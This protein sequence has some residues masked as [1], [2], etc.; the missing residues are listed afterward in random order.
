MVRVRPGKVA[1][2][3]LTAGCIIL[4]FIKSESTHYQDFL[5]SIP[6]IL[7]T[8][9]TEE[10][11][12]DNGYAVYGNAFSNATNNQVLENFQQRVQQMVKNVT[13][14]SNLKTTSKRQKI[15]IDKNKTIP[16]QDVFA[17]YTPAGYHEVKKIK[18]KKENIFDL[19]RELKRQKWKSQADDYKYMPKYLKA[20]A[21][22]YTVSIQHI[23]FF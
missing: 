7:K 2:T 20:R 14:K 11:K 13:N 1:L 19:Q 3:V 22:N 4:F 8:A 6:T 21:A 12:A 15:P 18:P 10:Y 5:N 9:P 17:D 23:S 16:Y